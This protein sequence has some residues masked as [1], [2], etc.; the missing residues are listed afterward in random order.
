MIVAYTVVAEIVYKLVKHVTVALYYC[1]LTFQFYGNAVL[2]AENVKAF[3]AFLAKLVYV[4]VLQIL[5][6]LVA[7]KL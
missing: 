1:G 2:F 4:H 3:P 5:W 6:N 7:F